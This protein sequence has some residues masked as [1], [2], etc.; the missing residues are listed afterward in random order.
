[1][2]PV[3]E[4]DTAAYQR[5]FTST[6]VWLQ[7]L[8]GPIFVH[9]DDFEPYA[10]ALSR[11]SYSTPEGKHSSAYVRN[12]AFLQ[13]E[14]DEAPTVE[15]MYTRPYIGVFKEGETVFSVSRNVEKVFK[16]GFSWGNP[17][18][19]SYY[20][21]G[22][23]LNIGDFKALA[24]PS[25]TRFHIGQGF[26]YYLDVKVGVANIKEKRLLVDNERVMQLVKKEFP[27]WIVEV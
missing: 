11:I 24:K 25:K 26:L 18:K 9:V 1:M 4:W 16:Q 27:E 6:W 10:D 12:G 15:I 2:I 21:A 14:V 20:G 13:K 8:K 22:G 17:F 3:I 23:G 19:V 7:E 5:K